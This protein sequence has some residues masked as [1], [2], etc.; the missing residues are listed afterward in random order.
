MISRSFTW[1]DEYTDG[2]E[3]NLAIQGAHALLHKYISA[4]ELIVSKPCLSIDECVRMGTRLPYNITQSSLQYTM[5][6][7]IE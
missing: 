1:L 5:S 2:Q 4:L 7:R 6:K 3:S